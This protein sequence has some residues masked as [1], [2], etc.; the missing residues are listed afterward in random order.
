VRHRQAPRSV[1]KEPILSTQPSQSPPTCSIVLVTYQSAGDLPTCLGSLP[2][3]A[4]P[5]GRP[6][7]AAVDLDV[8]VVDNASQDGSADLARNL[9]PT[10]G[11]PV[12]VIENPTNTGYASA[13]NLGAAAAGGEWLL[14]ANPDTRFAPGAVA[15]LVATAV[16]DPTIGC[17]G[18]HLRNPDGSDYPTGR[19]FPSVLV[20]AVHAALATVWAGNPATRFYH[21]TNVDRSVPIQVDWVSGACMLL[22]RETWDRVGGFDTGYFMYAEDMDLCL[23]V[24]RAGWRVVFDPRAEVEHT[25]GGSTRY[26][27]Y[28][29]VFDHHRSAFRFYLRHYQG[30]PR[31]VL[32]PAVAG[33]LTA[34]AGVSLLRT[35]LARRRER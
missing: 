26:R 35:Y 17:V 4:A 15:Q 22:R 27:P 21:M 11:L 20:G 16:A 13:A 29:K 31:I 12:K 33:F 5:E 14:V 3:A 9:G 8:V 34:R 32:S 1:S 28:R 24:K 25:V 2:Q 18:P 23:R 19:R 10:V 7:L 6:D 30:D